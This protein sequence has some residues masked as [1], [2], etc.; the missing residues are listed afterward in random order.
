MTDYEELPEEC[1]RDYVPMFHCGDTVLFEK[2][3]VKILGVNSGF[4]KIQNRRGGQMW[5][6]CETFDE[7]LL[8]QS[9]RAWQPIIKEMRTA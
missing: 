2:F 1:E 3:S 8:N 4:Y 9:V 5:I 7:C 6:G